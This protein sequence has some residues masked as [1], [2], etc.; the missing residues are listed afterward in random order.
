VDYG[1]GHGGFRAATLRLMSR[2]CG[3]PSVRCAAF[4]EAAEYMDAHPEL[5][6]VCE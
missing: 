3:L 2:V 6:G 1:G 4:R 5:E